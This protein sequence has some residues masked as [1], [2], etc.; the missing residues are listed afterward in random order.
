MEQQ[1][2]FLYL[3]LFFL[4]FLIWSTWAQRNAPAVSSNTNT[5]STLNGE[6]SPVSVP[7]SVPSSI[8]TAAE[9]TANG[10]VPQSNTEN[11][12]AKLI[13]I[14]TDV[15]DIQI[16]TVGGTIVQADL[17][18][19]PVSL[20]Q[21]DTP[22]RIIDK[23]KDYAAQSGLVHSQ[24]AGKN[25]ADLAPNHYAV[26]SVPESE[27]VLAE[28]QNTLE[29]PLTW[30]KNGLTVTKT[31]TFERGNYL[32]KQSQKVDNNSGNNWSASEYLQLSHAEHTRDGSLLESHWWLGSYHSTLLCRR[33]G[34]R[35]RS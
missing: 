29:V 26:F 35:E 22:V 20:E 7:T 10:T 5:T 18:A 12:V 8:P 16:N 31:F 24:I 30:S 6:S 32:V 2:P 4:C 33:L 9:N 14:K 3:S 17:P 27:Y 28:G 13:Q 23:L 1:R 15:L 21:Q 11:T 34:S 25:S 19:Y